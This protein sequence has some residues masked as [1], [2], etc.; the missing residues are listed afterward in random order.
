ME[1]GVVSRM[2]NKNIYIHFIFWR[3]FAVFGALFPSALFVAFYDPVAIPFVLIMTCVYIPLAIYIWLPGVFINHKKNLITIRTYDVF[4]TLKLPI[5]KVRSITVTEKRNGT[6]WTIEFCVKLKNGYIER[7]IYTYF[8][9]SLFCE[10]ARFDTIKKQV[11][12]AFPTNE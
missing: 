7:R 4:G 3:L 10:A 5:D 9:R 8:W 11:E 6:R 2:K 1:E 12:D